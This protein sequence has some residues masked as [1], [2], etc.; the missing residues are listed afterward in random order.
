MLA[1]LLN[2][3]LLSSIFAVVA[4]IALFQFVAVF[5]RKLNAI[6]LQPMLVSILVIMSFLLWQ[7]ISFDHYFASSW[8]LNALL[9]VSY[10]HLTLPT[11]REV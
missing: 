1:E 6:W 11:N 4:T 2:H 8:F 3:H 10:T 7:N 9:A 5:Q